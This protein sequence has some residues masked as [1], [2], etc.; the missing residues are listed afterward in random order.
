MI[1]RPDW[2]GASIAILLALAGCSAGAD[3][4]A[5]VD[6]TVA[7]ATEGGELARW[8]E[9]GRE[10]LAQGDLARAADAFDRA[11]AADADD[12]GL[13]VDIGRMRYRSGQQELAIAA[14]ERALAIDPANPQALLFQGQLARDAYGL[15]AGLAW[16]DRGLDVRPDDP[17]LLLDH[18][19]TLI[20]LDRAEEALVS[21]RHLARVA[22]ATPELP[23][24]QA[25][26]AARGGDF[27]L[28]RTLFQRVGPATRERPSARMLDGIIA[29]EQEQ[30]AS[31]A[32]IF[33][34]LLRQQPDNSRIQR[35][36]ARSLYL[37]GSHRQLVARFEEKALRGNASP[38]LQTLVGRSL[39]ALGR[40]GEAADFLDSAGWQDARTLT[41]LPPSA[42]LEA[43]LLD[44]K[45]GGIA[46]RD[47]VRASLDG[48]SVDEAGARARRYLDDAP[49]SGDALN[50]LG[51]AL[52]A[53][54]DAQGAIDAYTRAARIRRGWPLTLR[55]VA[56]ER[57]AGR[58]DR[59]EE[60]VASY[61]AQG[62]DAPEAVEL[63][64]RMLARSGAWTAAARVLDTAIENGADNPRILALRSQVALRL[65]D[66]EVALDRAWRAYRAQPMY[67]PAIAALAEATDDPA[68]KARLTEKLDRI[69]RR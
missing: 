65:G 28:A 64:G 62:G 27:V 44:E 26:I 10:R 46:A 7:T 4:S 66:R 11:L 50:L 56:A 47:F 33:D 22:P 34:A 17:A 51:D 1:S 41:P 12:A 21:L 31:A 38:Y 3:D 61:L 69:G 63:Y 25:V 18:A 40:R 14:A 29:L 16:F 35:L 36:L 60:L 55:L 2:I 67:V 52:L 6:R 45:G 57:L 19:A 49:G 15:L 39:E 13:W 37:G 42:P 59:A 58:P 43:A 8:R 9:L 54:G 48:S 24:L 68:L 23:Y 32:Q 5:P 30:Y 20:D 53:A